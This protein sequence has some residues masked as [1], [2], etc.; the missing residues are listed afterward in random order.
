M[1]AVTAEEWGACMT[2]APPEQPERK[3]KTLAEREAAARNR[4]VREMV[5]FSHVPPSQWKMHDRLVNWGRWSHGIT[6]E[7]QRMLHSPMFN[8]YKSS[9]ARRE[10]GA[11]T[12]LAIDH[13]D[14]TKIQVGVTALPDKHRRALAWNYLYPRN[15]T[16]QARE[17]GVSLPGLAD[18]ILRARLM[19]INRGV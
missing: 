14:A 13:M 15:P 18:L 3:Y 8:L 16:G 2:A 19:L 10:Y 5:D 7:R 11:L 9:D 1:G 6:G 4:V 17:L 12:V